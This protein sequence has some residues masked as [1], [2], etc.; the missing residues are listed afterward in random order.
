[1]NRN[2]IT[3]DW[4]IELTHLRLPHERIRGISICATSSFMRCERKVNFLIPNE[5]RIGRVKINF[6]SNRLIGNSIVR[7]FNNWNILAAGCSQQHY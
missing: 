1:M 6:Y 7:R 4:E 5:L 2:A 3:R